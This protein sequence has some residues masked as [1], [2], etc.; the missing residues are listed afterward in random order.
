MDEIEAQLIDYIDGTLS[1]AEAASVAAAIETNPAIKQAYEETLQLLHAM[2]DAPMPQPDG[3]LREGFMA[4]LATEMARPP[5]HLQLWGWR[6]AAAACLLLVGTI[7]G[8][9]LSNSQQ[10]QAMATLQQQLENTQ[11]MVLLS[12]QN[13]QSPSSRLQGLQVASAIEQPDASIV[14]ALLHTL[15]HDP[16]TNVRVATV[17]ALARWASQ[18]EVLNAL[19]AALYTE[20][21][22]Q[23]QLALIDV[24]VATRP[25]NA[26]EPLQYLA[27]DE[28]AL[29]VVRD[30]AQMGLFR[31]L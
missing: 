4:S 5:R 9:W 26:I 28:Q 8:M 3:R 11:Q 27:N 13:G 20:K 22:P 21:E 18:P 12:L 23:V 15:Q 25:A 14:N 16:N 1:Q 2:A 10:Q 29:P 6:A 30:E 31:M 7:V 19:V 17:K 24:A